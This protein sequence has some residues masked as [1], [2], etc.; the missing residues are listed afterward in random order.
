MPIPLTLYRYFW[1]CDPRL[2]D[3]TQHERSILDRL[4]ERGDLESVRWMLKTYDHSRIAD[5]VRVSRSLS[6]K[7]RNFWELYLH[8][9]PS[10]LHA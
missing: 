1:D 4:L 7:S 8:T 2:L 9:P 6:P 3:I 5:V 10:K